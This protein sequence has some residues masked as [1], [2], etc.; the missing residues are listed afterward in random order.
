MSPA[1]L[2]S[3]HHDDALRQ[4]RARQEVDDAQPLGEPQVSEG[5]RLQGDGVG[6]GAGRR[7]RLPG[8]QRAGLGRQEPSLG[9]Q[10]A[11]QV[12]QLGEEVQG[13]V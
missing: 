10:A 3:S 2:S 11:V 1:P 6:G 8:P 9:R 7:R 5:R 4:P 12:G 13:G